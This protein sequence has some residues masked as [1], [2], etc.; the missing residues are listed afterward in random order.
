MEKLIESIKRHEGYK[1]KAY[2]DTE[3]NLT[4][5]WGHYLRVG[6]KVPIEA[7]EAFFKTDLAQAIAD[8]WELPK[9]A[10][11]DLDQ[12]RRRVLVEMIFNM[13][14]GGVLKFKK[15]ITALIGRD[16]EEAANQMLDSKW[17]TQVKGRAIELAEIMRKGE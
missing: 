12:A 2:L 9:E 1:D 4:C 5:G 8:Y 7:S 13:G 17:A 3:G 14:L 6:S 11:R 16:Y 15:M 10:R